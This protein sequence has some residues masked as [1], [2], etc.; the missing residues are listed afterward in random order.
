MYYIYIYIYVLPQG[1]F[2]YRSGSFV[3]V[4]YAYDCPVFGQG[5]SLGPSL[6]KDDEDC[7]ARPLVHSIREIRTS[8]MQAAGLQCFNVSKSRLLFPNPPNPRVSGYGAFPEN[9]VTQLRLPTVFCQPLK[10]KS[11]DISIDLSIYLSRRTRI[12]PVP[13][14][15]RRWRRKRRKLRMVVLGNFTSQDL[16]VFQQLLRGFVVSADIRNTCWSL[17]IGNL[18]SPHITA[19]LPQQQLRRK[20]N[21]SW[22]TKFSRLSRPFQPFSVSPFCCFAAWAP[23]SFF[24]ASRS[25]VSANTSFRAS[26]FPFIRT[27]KYTH[28]EQ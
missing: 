6:A 11:H 27:S 7:C 21:K 15:W 22:L 4:S 9:S 10:Y 16:Y 3:F 12:Y 1:G 19:K 25:A 13:N 24:S 20:N 18:Q 14:P 28:S 5:S 2:G 17:Y 23:R 26:R 8:R